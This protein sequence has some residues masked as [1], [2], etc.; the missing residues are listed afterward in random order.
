MREKLE[1]KILVVGFMTFILGVLIAGYLVVRAQQKD[2][3]TIVTDRLVST[4][5]VITK[6]IEQTMLEGK[7]QISRSLVEDLK[8]VSGF[9]LK[10]FNWEG[11]AAFE[12]GS[13]VTGDQTLLSVLRIGNQE[14]LS[15]GGYLTAY[16]PLMKKASCQVCHEDEPNVIGS[17]KI[18]VS[19]EKE[20]HRMTL[21]LVYV[22]IG[23]I[24]GVGVIG[25]ILW[26]AMRRNIIAPLKSLEYAADM[27]AGGNLSF[28][29]QVFSNDEIGRLDQSIKKALNSISGMLLKVRDISRR[30]SNTAD[31]VEKDSDSVVE[32]SMLEGE[33]VAE[34]SSSVEELNAAIVEIADSTE[35]LAGLV[36][37]T[38]TSIEEMA[39]SISSITELT[40][41]VSEGVD[42]TSSSIEQMSATTK[43]VADN[44]DKLSKVSDETLSAVEEIIMSVKELENSAKE[45]AK[46]SERVTED[47]S[48]LGVDSI[49]KTIKGMEKIR[50]SV[51]RSS[52]AIMK[53]GGRSDEIVNIVDVIDD[54]A[55]QTT[56]LA[57]N[58]SILAAQAGEHGKGFSV[59][60]NEIKDLAER[61]VFS[62]QEIGALIAS[63]RNE[64]S[65]AVAAMREGNDAV[66]E[67]MRLTR[68]SSNALKKMLDSSKRSSEMSASIERTTTEQA[69]TARYVSEAIE[70]VRNMVDEIAKATSEQSRGA[71][72]IIKASEKMRDASHQA[73]KATSQ[74]DEVSRQVS[75]TVENISERTKQ[76]SRA[77]Q[78]QKIGAKQ[79]WSSVEKIKDIPEKTRNL[80][81]SINKAVRELSKNS[82]LMTVELDRFKLADLEYSSDIMFSVVP[83]DMPSSIYRKFTPLME[84]LSR[85]TGRQF[86]LRVS[87]DF[88]EAVREMNEGMVH[89][90]FMN[91]LAYIRS[92]EESGAKL[93][94]SMLRGGRA[95]QKAVVV[96]KDDSK[97]SKLSDISNR[98]FAF[99]DP[100]SVSGYLMPVSLLLEEGIKL[101]N[102]AYHNF[103]G[104]HEEVIRAILKGD[105]DAG[106][107]MESVAA[108][109]KGRGIKILSISKEIPE[110]IVCASSLFPNDD[111]GKIKKALL[112]LK[113]GTPDALNVLGNIDKQYTGCVEAFDHDFDSVRELMR[114]TGESNG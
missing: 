84:Y 34:I 85:K 55:D 38:A 5:Q 72:L 31:N 17:V 100:Y 16:M 98:S 42:A 108:A 105:F 56:L 3:N 39:K 70:R 35:A 71:N 81:F 57:L 93:L 11:R 66:E 89:L 48:A 22:I 75:N 68:D 74:Q 97:I 67:G 114:K 58:A 9:D 91:S 109:Y 69:R 13:P 45:A 64:V 87:S 96:V 104:S 88:S 43:E 52:T 73:D 4:A 60:A 110:F 27:M 7:A 95:T 32:S 99:V 77:I 49:N 102:L 59:V 101:T 78:E 80:S 86:E 94:A 30:V 15:E 46:L 62:T 8:N 1:F 44:A 28:S 51:E 107:V 37:G 61:T 21:F 65:D 23:S 36:E 6:S 19:L 14:I 106:S 18:S 76:I 40:H 47:A 29:T 63:V 103:L 83:F 26:Q 112:M 82:E 92:Q 2:I 10:V 33:A 41:D 90:S 79:I 25:T 113:D 24:L 12:K 54:I 53:L 111:A 20:Y 50:D